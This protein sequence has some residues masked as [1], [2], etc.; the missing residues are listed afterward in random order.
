M[1]VFEI[2]DFCERV[3]EYGLDVKLRLKKETNIMKGRIVN[4]TPKSF[5]FKIQDGVEIS[6]LYAHVANISPA[7]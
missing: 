5:S 7:S 1:S 3:S 6:I 4:L 2:K